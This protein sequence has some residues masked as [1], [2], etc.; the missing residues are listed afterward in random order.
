VVLRMFELVRRNQ[1][2]DHYVA[3]HMCDDRLFQRKGKSHAYAPEKGGT[4]VRTGPG[5]WR[6][7][8][9]GAGVVVGA[10]DVQDASWT[11]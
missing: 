6:T 4:L 2:V 9:C 8:A 7:Y 1:L 5:A 10:G 11:G 3:H